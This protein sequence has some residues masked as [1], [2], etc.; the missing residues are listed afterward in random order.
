MYSHSGAD[1][2]CL[3]QLVS[4]LASDR[5]Y[6]GVIRTLHALLCLGS[7]ASHDDD[8]KKKEKRKKKSKPRLGCGNCGVKSSRQR[9]VER[10]RDASLRH[11]EGTGV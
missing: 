3:D 4:L 1:S 5:A 9:S 11:Q 10:Q 8:K 2:A 7:A 6:L